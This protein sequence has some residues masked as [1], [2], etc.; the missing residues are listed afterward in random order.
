MDIIKSK[1]INYTNW[2]DLITKTRGYS[3]QECFYIVL[4]V[5]VIRYGAPVIYITTL[6]LIT[7]LFSKFILF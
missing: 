7:L 6:A 2:N 1:E 4:K 5:F 3:L